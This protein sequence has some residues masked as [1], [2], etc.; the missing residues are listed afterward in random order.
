MF[1]NYVIWYTHKGWLVPL[2]KHETSQV[3]QHAKVH[4]LAPETSTGH[5]ELQATMIRVWEIVFPGEKNTSIEIGYQSL[6]QYQMAR[7][8]NIHKRT[9]SHLQ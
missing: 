3:P 1:P 4:G 5:K 2:S 6:I 7:S 9:Y 8:E